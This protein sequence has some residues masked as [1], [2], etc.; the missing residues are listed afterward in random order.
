MLLLK[1]KIKVKSFVKLMIFF[2]KFIRF[3]VKIE[4]FF[5]NISLNFC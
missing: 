3:I 2:I 4:I 5:E 1:F